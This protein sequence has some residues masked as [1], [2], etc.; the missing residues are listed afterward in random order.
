MIFS[1]EDKQMSHIAYKRV[2]G[3]HKS[4]PKQVEI[5]STTSMA[6]NNTTEQKMTR[7]TEGMEI[8]TLR[9]RW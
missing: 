5:I 2:A 8:E 1:K 9:Q 7:T 4:S 6:P 3:H